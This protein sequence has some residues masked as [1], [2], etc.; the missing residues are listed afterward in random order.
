ML[1]RLPSED[2]ALARVRRVAE[3]KLGHVVRL[4][5]QPRRRVMVESALQRPW[6]SLMGKPERQMDAMRSRYW[7][8]WLCGFLI[9]AAPHYAVGQT[10][11][12]AAAFGDWR[13]DKPELDRR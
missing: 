6:I 9:V 4:E 3:Q 5:V 8:F 2:E 1:L 10:L 11:D 12:G 7:S 13:S